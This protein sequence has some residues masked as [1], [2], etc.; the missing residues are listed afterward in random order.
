[1]A[2]KQTLTRTEGYA[3]TDS[4]KGARIGRDH[5]A[6]RSAIYE[7]NAQ[8]EQWDCTQRGLTI[9]HCKGQFR[10]FIW[11]LTRKRFVNC[12]CEQCTR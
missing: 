9:G 1:M 2:T 12:T 10:G 3:L 5:M 7:W 11:S 6:T 4:G 8:T